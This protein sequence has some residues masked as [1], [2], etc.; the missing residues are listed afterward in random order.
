M[1]EAALLQGQCGAV[2]AALARVAPWPRLALIN[3]GSFEG[4]F[5]LFLVV[6]SLGPGCICDP[7]PDEPTD[8]AL[9]LL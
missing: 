9:G 5:F 7:G 2:Q 1:E 4:Y 3:K 8:R 6:L